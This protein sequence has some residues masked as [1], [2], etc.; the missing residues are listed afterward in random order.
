MSCLATSVVIAC[1]VEWS[2]LIWGGFGSLLLLGG[3]VLVL[4]GRRT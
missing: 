4:I 3:A 1:S 2:T